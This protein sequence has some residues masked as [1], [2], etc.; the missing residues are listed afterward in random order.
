[1]N[2]KLAYMQPYC[3]QVIKKKKINLVVVCEEKKRVGGEY[4]L[5]LFLGNL[6]YFIRKYVKIKTEM[7]CEF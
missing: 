2:R 7:Y 1:M 3:S 6:Y 5:L 4:F